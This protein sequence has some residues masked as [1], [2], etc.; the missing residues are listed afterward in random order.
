M[1]KKFAALRVF[2]DTKHRPMFTYLASNEGF[3]IIFPTGVKRWSTIT[4]SNAQQYLGKH[5]NLSKVSKI[6][7]SRVLTLQH[8]RLARLFWTRAK[9]SK[10][11]WYLDKVQAIKFETDLLNRS[12]TEM[13]WPQYYV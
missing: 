2:D 12:R 3:E 9:F 8:L 7:P 10:P 1:G 6:M 11:I 13:D 4:N 5:K